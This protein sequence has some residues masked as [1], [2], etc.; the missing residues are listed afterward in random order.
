MNKN[1]FILELKD[2]GQY[3]TP[4]F[5][6]SKGKEFIINFNKHLSNFNDIFKCFQLTPPKNIKIIWQG[7]EPFLDETS[8]G[9]CFSSVDNINPSTKVIFE[10][11][12]ESTNIPFKDFNLKEGLSY[13]SEQGILLLNKNLTVAKGKPL[14]HTKIWEGFNQYFF[15]IIKEKFPHVSIV[16]F[17]QKAL[18]LDIVFDKNNPLYVLKHPIFCIKNK[19]K[20]DLNRT[21]ILIN[22]YLRTHFNWAITYNYALWE[23]KKQDMFNDPEADVIKMMDDFKLPF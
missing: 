20:L 4:F 8:D 12:A 16:V 13:L 11:I 1:D 23:E 6:S 19:I 18:P 21:F 22:D 3:F 2:W 14:S 15:N 10:A 5:N 7:V 9:L 17:G